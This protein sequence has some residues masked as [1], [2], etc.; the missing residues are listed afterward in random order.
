MHSD[1]PHL[2][3]SGELVSASSHDDNGEILQEL[4][5]YNLLPQN[6]W[7]AK[8]YQLNP[9]GHWDDYGTGEFQLIRDVLFP[10]I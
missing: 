2:P 3:D 7:R 8:L 9:K 5:T 4:S 10:L 1:N 6:K